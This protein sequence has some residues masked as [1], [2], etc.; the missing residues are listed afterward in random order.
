MMPILEKRIM[1]LARNT[2]YSFAWLPLYIQSLWGGGGGGG[3]VEQ[4]GDSRNKNNNLRADLLICLDV[5]LNRCK[6]RV[7]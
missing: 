3:G 2:V 4:R 6:K 1:N 5:K 7:Q